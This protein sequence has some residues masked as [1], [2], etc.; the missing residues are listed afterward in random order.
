VQVSVSLVLL[1][2][3]GL[4]LRTLQNAYAVDPGYDVEGVLL[5]D[6][7]LDVSGD[8][9][10]AGA[11][12]FRRVLDRA[13]TV[14]G[15]RSIAA[16][17]AAVLSGVNRSVVV[18]TDGQPISETNRLIARVNVV[19]DGYFETLGI[20]RLRGRDFAAVDTPTAPRVAVVTRALAD[21]LWPQSDPIGRTL[22]TGTGP[23]EVVG[24]VADNVYVSV[25]EADPPPFFYLPLSQNY[26]ALFTLHV[27]TS[28]A[29]AM[30]AL[31]GIRTAIREIDPRVVVTR[32]RTLENEFQRSIDDRRLVAVMVGL[33]GGLALLLTAMGLYGL[34]AFAVGQRTREIGVRMAFGAS[35]SSVVGMVLRQGVWLVVVGTTVGVA[36][37]I[38]LS[39]FI[40]SQLF[41]VAPTDPFAFA[42]AIAILLVV[43]AVGCLI[44]ARRAA[45]VDPLVA[46]RAE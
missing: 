37:A 19:S 6:V 21:R 15:V 10:A 43:A 3:A 34:M 30:S 29:D 35:R 2:G 24:V 8:G 36:L 32:T 44:P 38:A 20:P 7:N 5:A 41:G 27:R 9:A 12:V 40:R 28:A 13:A 26:E 25:T 46:L 22:M 16:A 11:E 17:R 1:V 33:F 31:T 45:R 39:R 14:P 23:L 42:A 4:S 18:S